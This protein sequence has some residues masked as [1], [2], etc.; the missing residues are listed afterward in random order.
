MGCEY[1]YPA[2]ISVSNSTT[3][4]TIDKKIPVLLFINQAAREMGSK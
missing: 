2:M 1:V 3:E 4:L